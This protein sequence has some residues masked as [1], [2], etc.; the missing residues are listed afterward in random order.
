MFRFKRLDWVRALKLMVLQDSPMCCGPAC[1]CTRWS[2]A[3][4]LYMIETVRGMTLR[5]SGSPFS[6]IDREQRYPHRIPTALTYNYSA[7]VVATGVDPRA[8]LAA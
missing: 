3:Y 8:G 7:R 6:T 4:W 2:L 5:Q 1:S